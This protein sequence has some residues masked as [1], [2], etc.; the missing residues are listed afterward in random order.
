YM[1]QLE[2]RWRYHT[3]TVAISQLCSPIVL[4]VSVVGKLV[5]CFIGIRDTWFLRPTVRHRQQTAS[6]ACHS[7]LGRVRF[8]KSAQLFA[9]CLSMRH[10][11]RSRLSRMLSDVVAG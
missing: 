11:Q 5:D 4:L 3:H 7:I 6:T 8:S 1:S 2:K 9:R 10:S